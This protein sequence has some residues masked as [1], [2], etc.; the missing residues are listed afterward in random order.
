MMAHFSNELHLKTFFFNLRFW[1]EV[2]QTFETKLIS[3]SFN[4][5]SKWK[6]V[7]WFDLRIVLESIPVINFF[8]AQNAGA[9]Q[10]TYFQLKCSLTCST[11]K[12]K[13]KLESL[14]IL[15]H[16][17]NSPSTQEAENWVEEISAVLSTESSPALSLVLI[18]RAS[19]NA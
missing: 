11:A 2:T 12:K 3:K 13:C 14:W 5:S 16:Q 8:L 18:T 10:I 9:H 15:L 6:N 7:F 19:R 17:R 1:L 4:H